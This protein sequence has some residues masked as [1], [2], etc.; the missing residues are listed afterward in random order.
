MFTVKVGFHFLILD[1]DYANYAVTLVCGTIP[2]INKNIQLIWIFGR[3]RTME[4]E[5]NDKAIAAL[6]A[7]KESTSN[8]V[9]TVQT[10]CAD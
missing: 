2:M 6:E 8:F 3:T 10:G 5:F 9:E 4:S 1:T 7:R